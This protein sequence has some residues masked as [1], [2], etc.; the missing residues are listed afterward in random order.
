MLARRGRAG[1]GVSE[2]QRGVY[3][4]HKGIGEGLFVLYI[5][6]LIVVYLLGRRGQAVPSWL[7]GA[8]HGLLALQVALGVILLAEGHGDAVPWYHPVLGIV[9]LLALGLAAP[10]RKRLGAINGLVA[11]FAIIA[12]LTLFARVAAM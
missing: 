11:L 5:V 3:D 8:S 4:I 7:V 10:L 12:V 9:A 2:E 6:V 1:V